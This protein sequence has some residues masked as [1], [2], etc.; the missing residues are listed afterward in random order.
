LAENTLDAVTRGRDDA[1]KE[2][3]TVSPFLRVSVSNGLMHLLLT[4][5]HNRFNK[6]LEV[7]V[8]N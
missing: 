5:S 1:E 6:H 8:E 7:S 2:P 4:H 3:N